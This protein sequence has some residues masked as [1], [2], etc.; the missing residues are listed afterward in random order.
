MRQ[1]MQKHEAAV[2]RAAEEKRAVE[3]ARRAEEERREAAR[4]EAQ[5]RAEAEAAERARALAARQAQKETQLEARARELSELRALHQRQRQMRAQYARHRQELAAQRE[6]ERRQQLTWRLAT[7]EARVAGMEAERAAMLQALE[8]VRQDIRRQED[9]LRQALREMQQRDGAPTGGE[10][11]RLQRVLDDLVQQP[12][13]G[14]RPASRGAAGA[15]LA[16][17]TLHAPAAQPA[18]LEA[19]AVEAAMQ[20]LASSHGSH[21][22]DSRANS[23]R[24]PAFFAGAHAGVSC[25]LS[26]GELGGH[27]PIGVL[28]PA[29]EDSIEEHATADERQRAEQQEAEQQHQHQRRVSAAESPADTLQRLVEAELAREEE[30]EAMLARVVV[31]GDRARLQAFFETERSSAMALMQELR[32][33]MAAMR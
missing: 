6:E 7:K 10:L 15:R 30:R 31:A 20:E 5:A 2:A 14:S 29:A 8:D 28:Y 9:S 13:P 25:S 19:A 27:E 26:A 18:A 33:R 24:I 12:Q 3:A 16:S 17:R 4:H 11:A 22:V 32:R 23:P 1:K 21:G